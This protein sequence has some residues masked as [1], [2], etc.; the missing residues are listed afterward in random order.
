MFLELAG[1]FFT[2]EPPGKPIYIYVYIYIYTHIHIYTHTYI[3]IGCIYIYIGCVYINIYIHTS[4][5]QGY[6]MSDCCDNTDTLTY[7]SE[8]PEKSP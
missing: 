3:Y 6:I 5:L 7:Y 4:V 2:T 1:R 8:L